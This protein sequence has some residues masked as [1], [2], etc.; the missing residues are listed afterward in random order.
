[1]TVILCDQSVKD[2]ALADPGKP[3]NLG[4]RQDWICYYTYEFS[5]A[6][7][8]EAVTACD[9]EGYML[10]ILNSQEH[11]EWFTTNI[12]QQYSADFSDIL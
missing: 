6:T 11:K 7:W 5:K 8:L 9:S 4:C 2:V 1:M 3:Q 10:P 12:I